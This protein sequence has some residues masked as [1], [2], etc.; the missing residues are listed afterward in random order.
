MVATTKIKSVYYSHYSMMCIPGRAEDGSDSAWFVVPDVR[1][2]Q[3]GT[4]IYV[5][6]G[7]RAGERARIRAGRLN[8]ARDRRL[9]ARA[10]SR[11][12]SR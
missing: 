9:N 7:D 4:A 2:Y 5:G 10:Q 1:R 11:K 12:S 3:P 6:D 8:R